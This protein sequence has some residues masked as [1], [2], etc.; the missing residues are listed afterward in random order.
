MLAVVDWTDEHVMIRAS[1]SSLH[2]S[3]HS[4][5]AEVLRYS[6]VIG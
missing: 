2:C 1:E 3:V 4:I 6:S 5:K